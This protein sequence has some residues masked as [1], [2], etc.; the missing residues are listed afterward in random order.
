MIGDYQRLSYDRTQ[1][2][3]KDIAYYNRFDADVVVPAPKAYVVPQA[4]REV[5]ERLRWNG[6]E[7][8]PHHQRTDGNGA[9]LPYRGSRHA[10]RRLR[11]PYV[12]RDG[13]TGS[14]H[15]AVHPAAGRLCDHAWTR[16]MPATRWKRWSR[17]RTT[18]FSAGAFSTA[19]WKKRKRF[20]TMCS[21]T[22]RS[23]LLRD[24]PALAAKFAEWKTANPALLSN[25]E[26]VLDFIF[27]HCATLCRAGM[28][29]LSGAGP[30]V[31]PAASSLSYPG[32]VPETPV[33]R[34]FL[35]S[36]HKVQPCT[37]H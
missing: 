26:A 16:T 25:Q 7:M 37:T 21:K 23:E 12:P 34:L 4:W 5:I 36:T 19:C 31:N 3:E 27:E 18:A 17:R 29:P 32:A 8:T 22:W 35:C 20:P 1:P 2:W 6:V 14:A 28:A 33:Q 30:D 9:L 24:E 13:G 15:G 11:R 10:R